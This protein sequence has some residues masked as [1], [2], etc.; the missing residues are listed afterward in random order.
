MRIVLYFL[1]LFACQAFALSATELMAARL[2]ALEAKVI[3]LKQ[4]SYDFSDSTK[5]TLEQ[6]LA[7][8]KR[9]KRNVQIALTLSQSHFSQ[10]DAE[11]SKLNEQINQAQ[12]K[13]SFE[14]IKT[15]LLKLTSQ[16]T[17]YKKEQQVLLENIEL[18]D[19][20]IKETE[21]RLQQIERDSAQALKKQ[22]NLDIEQ[23]IEALRQSTLALLK[24]TVAVSTEPQAK[25]AL[26]E[27][28]A[29]FD[30][31][32]NDIEIELL[33]LNQKIN[34]IELQHISADSFA[35][36]SKLIDSDKTIQARLSQK[37]LVLT[38]IQ[39]E[40]S[41]QCA[42]NAPLPKML[43]QKCHKQQRRI[44]T[45]LN[46]FG[47][48]QLIIEQKDKQY[49][50]E[51]LKILQTRKGLLFES[52]RQSSQLGHA[53]LTIPSIV[54]HYSLAVFIQL[55]DMFNAQSPLMQFM[56]LVLGLA[57]VLISLLVR[58]LMINHLENK[59]E[60]ASTLAYLLLYRIICR[61]GFLI[62]A[63]IGLLLMASVI[64]L[65]ISA[66]KLLISLLLVL[67]GFSTVIYLTRLALLETLSNVSG[68]DVKLYH[69]LRWTFIVGAIITLV[70]VLCHFLT[71]NYLLKELFDRLFMFFLLTVSI[72]L[73]KG[74][75]VLTTLLHNYLHPKK[76]Y[77][78]RAIQVSVFLVPLALLINGLVGVFGFVNL[79]WEMSY[80]QAVI[81]AVVLGYIMLRGLL[82]DG[83][84]F[85]SNKMIAGMDNGWLWTE[86]ILK[87]FHQLIRYLLIALMII[88]VF[89]LYGWD[90]DASMLSLINQ[91]WHFEVIRFT[92][93]QVTIKSLVEF[94]AML[95]I[96]SW[97]AKWSREFCYRWIYQSVSD[98]GL[99]NSLSVFSQYLIIS[100]L[101]VVTLAVLGVDTSGISMILGGLA[102]GMGFGLRDFANNII[103]GMMLLIERPVKEGDLISL[104]NIEGRVTHI[105]IRSMRVKS[106]DNYEVVIPNADAFSKPFTN[107]THKDS[108]VRTVLPIKI[109]R[110]DSPTKIQQL[111]FDVLN[112]IPEVLHDPEPQ[113]FMKDIDE[114]LIELEVRY[115]IDITQ[116]ARTK[117]RSV[118]LFAIMAQF[119]AAGIKA[120]I[121]ALQVE[122]LEDKQ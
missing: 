63:V 37:I 91:V 51:K 42:A 105:G 45:L 36:I 87:P 78:R 101:A 85:L 27:Q 24:P 62:G 66:Y 98:L 92:K 82:I 40:Q 31:L 4:V 12:F 113:V 23:K 81:V 65:P 52:L 47:Q 77:T 100:L 120:P 110:H 68:L 117:V 102:V 7:S 39:Q 58:K 88:L 30:V 10:L 75:R 18:I 73:L 54:G 122:H 3:Q 70:T 67:I 80:Y 33:K 108:V 46:Q 115:Y 20:H 104:D 2:Q 32:L 83:L 19:D 119:K 28:L 79:A 14:S 60:Q 71:L 35:T 16:I 56:T 21:L 94:F 43:L 55:K 93:M 99:R 9:Q 112:I 34:D 61:N 103:G 57:F 111:I 97:M 6:Q 59:K 25:A 90:S 118:V 84:E 38:Q 89:K 41:Q 50:S 116:H 11:R 121:P 8:L 29:N 64:G 26:L 107:W 69:R 13:A 76:F 49:Q 15:H 17:L 114:V 1:A 95:A 48:H 72:V 5:Q 96:L 44:K 109:N 86:S 22:K 106:W 74:Q 53:L